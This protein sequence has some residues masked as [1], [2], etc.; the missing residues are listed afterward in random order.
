MEA[1]LPLARRRGWHLPDL[2]V[3]A[4]A[5][6]TTS[7]LAT[8]HGSGRENFEGLVCELQEHDSSFGLDW[9]EMEGDGRGG[10]TSSPQGCG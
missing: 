7:R 6:W 10:A 9:S 8:L 1:L 3:L 4:R 2:E 5:G